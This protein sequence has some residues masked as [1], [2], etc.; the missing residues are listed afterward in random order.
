MIKTYTSI[1]SNIFNNSNNPK[2]QIWKS[3]PRPAPPPS[4]LLL[5]RGNDCLQRVL[6]CP[7][8]PSGHHRVEIRPSSVF[9]FFM[10][11]VVGGA[12]LGSACSMLFLFSLTQLALIE[13][14]KSCHCFRM[15]MSSSISST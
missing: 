4:D 14:P 9:S 2:Q 11:M 6:R 8:H 12:A 3:K 10:T 5:R 15:L 7:A 13:I 1:T